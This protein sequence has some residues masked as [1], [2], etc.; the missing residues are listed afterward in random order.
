VQN[1][2]QNT[3]PAI[4]QQTEDWRPSERAFGSRRQQMLHRGAYHSAVVAHIANKSVELRPEILSELEDALLALARFDSEI[5]SMVAPFSSML[6]RSEAAS[7]SQ[8]ENLTS[9]PSSV[10]RAEFGLGETANSALI[11]SN[12]AA[13]KS[14]LEASENLTVESLLKMHSALM[15][16][17]DPLNAGQLR[18]QPVWI[19]GSSI[20]PHLADY[21]APNYASVKPLM[22][23]LVEFCERTDIPALA[24]IAIAHSQFETI[25][26]FI[27]GNGR[28][29]RAL[30]QALLNRMQITKTVM[31]PVSAGLLKNTDTYFAALTAYRAGNL[32][33]IIRAFINAVFAAVENGRQLTQQLQAARMRWQAAV[34]TR[35]DSAA[36]K[37]L[38]NLLEQPVITVKS[39]QD[40]LN[41]TPATAT[42][43][44][45]QLCSLGV[46]AQ[47][48]NNKRNRIWQAP[49]I[50]EA[51]DE[52]AQRCR[53]QV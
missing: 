2:E 19:S 8:I 12:Q 5:G 46:L 38:D 9:S 50:I 1:S 25:H 7:S 13:L 32:E 10:L 20:G 17:A 51:L 28:T 11:L 45:E 21:V 37:L 29:G 15:A 34:Q 52:F 42:N 47:I 16:S 4:G 49:E 43:A 6:L 26:P 23:D 3:W 22:S 27:D 35:S 53:R 44:I 14:A 33:P 39:V 31:V 18:E 30:V 40:L 41:V 24:Q 48:G 36:S